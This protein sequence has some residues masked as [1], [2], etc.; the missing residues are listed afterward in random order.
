MQWVQ[1]CSI[2]F[3]QKNMANSVYQINKGINKS[4]EFK[5]LKA[6][7]IWYL[8][9]GIVGLLVLFAA[10]YIIGMNSF[11]CLGV[12]LVLGALLVFKVYGMSNKYGEH[13]MM[14]AV[15]KR[16]IPNVIRL[17]SRKIF[18]NKK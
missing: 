17:N 7:Y 13:G 14:K 16:S 3:K 9:A 11:V 2:E 18:M 8:G 4:I 12:I 10:M 5:G 1:A 6:Q 15:A